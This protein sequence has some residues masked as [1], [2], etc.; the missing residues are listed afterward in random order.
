MPKRKTKFPSNQM[1]EEVRKELDKGPASRL[2]KRDASP[3]E[4]TKY[5]ICEKFVVYKNEKRL[6]QRALA[7]KINIDE[8]LMSKILHYQIDEFTTDRLIKYLSELHPDV[9]I[10]V[11]VA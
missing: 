7:E 6:T 8:A 4:K 3:V 1:L 10:N 9:E 5:R 2:L 11:E